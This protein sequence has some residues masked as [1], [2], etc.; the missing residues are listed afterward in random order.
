MAVILFG[1]SQVEANFPTLTS[2]AFPTTFHST[3]S[4]ALNSLLFTSLLYHWASF[5][6]YSAS[7]MVANSRHSSNESS[8]FTINSSF[9]VGINPETW[10]LH[11]CTLVGMT[12][13]VSYV[14]E[15]GVSPVD[16]LGVVQYAH[17]TLCSSSAHLPLVPSNRFFKPFTI[18]LLV[19]SA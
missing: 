10:A 17:K 4:P 1:P 5:C 6:W 2:L 13:S 8:C 9:L 11:K 19:A 16:L 18:A 3:K 15:N 7:H 12:T 14:R